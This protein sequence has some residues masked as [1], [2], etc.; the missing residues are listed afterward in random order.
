M[1]FGG[2]HLNIIFKSRFECFILAQ[3]IS[4]PVE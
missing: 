1:E 3:A 4:T 2:F